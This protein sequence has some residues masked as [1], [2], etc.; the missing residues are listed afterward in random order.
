[1]Y[2]VCSSRTLRHIRLLILDVDGVM[3]DGRLFYGNEGRIY[4]AFD[5]HDGMGIVRARQAGIKVAMLS[6]KR[7]EAIVQRAEDLGIEDCLQ[8]ISDK[9]AAYT[10]LLTKYG[11]RDDQVAY[12]GD[13]VNDLL[14]M[15]RAGFK[16]AVRNAREEVKEV[17]DYVTD[18]EGG[19]GAVREV[20]DLVLDAQ[21][22]SVKGQ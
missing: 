3:T 9:G 12:I 15:E 8:G 1:M 4:R 6:G 13:D 14:A 5:V 10:T 22:Q 16:V 11:L 20:V 7:S 17:A 18:A 19:R 21:Q 2:A